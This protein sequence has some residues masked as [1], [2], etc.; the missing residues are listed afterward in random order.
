M[1]HAIDT[2]MGGAHEVHGV[3]DIPGRALGILA[4]VLSF[5]LPVVALVLGVIADDRSRRAGVSNGWAIAAVV[6]NVLVIVTGTVLAIVFSG[7][8]AAVG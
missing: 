7:A 1:D 3:H 4:F 5:F 2:P 8:V 6:V